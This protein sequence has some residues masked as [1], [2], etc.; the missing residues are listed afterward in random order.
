[1]SS[2][3]VTLVGQEIVFS[4]FIS[5]WTFVIRHCNIGL[6]RYSITM[7]TNF[8]NNKSDTF[9]YFTSLLCVVISAS[10][11][12]CLLPVIEHSTRTNKEYIAHQL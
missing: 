8:P 2:R 4:I 10:D 1:M 5:S 7:S 12:Y 11:I 3:R 6:I 9:L